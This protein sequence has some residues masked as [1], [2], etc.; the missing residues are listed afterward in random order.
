MWDN[1]GRAYLADTGAEISVFPAS[2]EDRRKPTQTPLA[3]ANGTGI[4]TWGRRTIHLKLGKRDFW[5]EFILAEVTRPI[6]GADFF[7]T[8]YILPDLARKRLVDGSE[9]D[10]ASGTPLATKIICQ[11]EA[12]KEKNEFEQLLSNFP[13]IL[14]PDFKT[15]ENKH[16]IYHYIPT[17]GPPVFAK[18]RRLDKAKLKSAKRYFQEMEELGT[19]RCLAPRGRRPST[20]S[21]KQMGR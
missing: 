5:Q 9:D 13:S 7:S 12:G 16:K 3:A 6:L 14:N 19:I 11:V 2:L 4:K 18:P 21:R 17:K 15:E 10:W 20:W 8:N 1:S